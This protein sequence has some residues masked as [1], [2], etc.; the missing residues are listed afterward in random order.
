MTLRNTF[1]F[2]GVASK[3]NVNQGV[4]RF[5]EL[6]S[7][8]KNLKAPTNTVILKEPYCFNKEYSQKVLNELAITTIK[9]LVQSTEIYFDNSP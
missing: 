6:L 9:Q 7:V 2:A 1:H 5:K 8:S 4:P 3:A